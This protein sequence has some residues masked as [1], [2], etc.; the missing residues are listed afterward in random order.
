MMSGGE[1]RRA[2]AEDHRREIACLIARSLAL[3][4]ARGHRG[5]QFFL[6]L[7]GA[8]LYKPLTWHAFAFMLAVVL[9]F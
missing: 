8:A 6:V 1:D 4:A 9:S 5:L 3:S 7:R 2:G